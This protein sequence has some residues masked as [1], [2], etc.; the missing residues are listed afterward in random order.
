MKLG[1][2]MLYDGNTLALGVPYKGILDH[3]EHSTGTPTHL[4]HQT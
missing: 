2:W 4:S 1:S 3:V